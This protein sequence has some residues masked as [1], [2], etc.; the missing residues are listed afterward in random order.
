[1]DRFFMLNF[2]ILISLK[3]N[4]VSYKTKCLLK[5]IDLF[6]IIYN[7]MCSC[8]LELIFFSEDDRF[9][10]FIYCVELCTA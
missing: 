9:N 3:F 4:E 7:T 10:D 6:V 8:H 2:I 1:M 5:C